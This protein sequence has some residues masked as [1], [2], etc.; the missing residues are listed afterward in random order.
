MIVMAVAHVTEDGDKEAKRKQS[1]ASEKLRT[2]HNDPR[3]SKKEPRPNSLPRPMKAT[4]KPE[5]GYRLQNP[6]RYFESTT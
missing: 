4:R 6:S 2:I 5:S 3:I 1:Q